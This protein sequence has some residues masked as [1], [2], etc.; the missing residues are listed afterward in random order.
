VHVV[1]AN[2][3]GVSLASVKLNKLATSVATDITGSTG[4]AAFTGVAPGSYT[5]NVTFNSAY[6][7]A[8]SE[9]NDK[10][11]TVTAGADASVTFHSTA[12][13]PGGR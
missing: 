13:V 12:V 10:P 4:V 8:A 9:T 2:N 6:Q 7:L 11:V 3:A 1:D 5:I